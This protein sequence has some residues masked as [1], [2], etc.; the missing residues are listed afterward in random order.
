MRIGEI[1]SFDVVAKCPYCD[2][3]TSVHECEAKHG[4]VECQHCEESFSIHLN[5]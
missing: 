2:N 1:T 3:E 5:N 4:T